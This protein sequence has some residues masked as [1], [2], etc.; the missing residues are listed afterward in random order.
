MSAV[1]HVVAPANFCH[2]PTVAKVVEARRCARKP[3][4]LGIH[5]VL[6]NALHGVSAKLS[7]AHVVQVV[8]MRLTK[9]EHAVVWYATPTVHGTVQ[10]VQMRFSA[11]VQVRVSYVSPEHGALH[12]EQTRS[13]VAD[14]ALD[15]YV[16]PL[17]HSV[18]RV[19]LSTRPPR[20]HVPAG[21]G[22]HSVFCAPKHALDT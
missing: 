2:T 17:M 8:Q 1:S 5:T 21:H 7:A 6:L 22:L 12:V 15:S 4:I 9:L 16:V 20:D 13:A 3:T 18:H 19:Q 14:G 11:L 10:F